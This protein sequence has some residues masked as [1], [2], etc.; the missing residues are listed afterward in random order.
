MTAASLSPPSPLEHLVVELLVV[1][2]KALCVE[3]TQ[4][5]RQVLGLGRHATGFSQVVR[6]AARLGAVVLA[7]G[8]GS[9][10]LIGQ[11]IVTGQSS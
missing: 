8:A 11:L 10:R 6:Q 3:A 7:C 9:G 2:L 1:R 5:H 4:R